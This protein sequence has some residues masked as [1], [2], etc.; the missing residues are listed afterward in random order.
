MMAFENKNIDVKL[1][2]KRRS[3]MILAVWCAVIGAYSEAVTQGDAKSYGRQHGVVEPW[4]HAL[5]RPAAG[6]I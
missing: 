5:S 2:V 6:Q 3:P 4:T 1:D